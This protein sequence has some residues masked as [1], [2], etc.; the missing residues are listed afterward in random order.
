[1]QPASHR[2]NLFLSGRTDRAQQLAHVSLVDGVDNSLVGLN[3]GAKTSGRRNTFV[4]ANVATDASAASNNVAVGALAGETAADVHDNV[5]LGHAAGQRA[6]TATFNVVAGSMAGRD[7]RQA[8]FNVLLG[9]RAA[10]EMVSGARNVVLGAYA[11]YYAVNACDNVFAGHRAGMNNRL[12]NRNT[13][14]GA[15]TGRNNLRGNTNVFIGSDAGSNNTHGDDNVFLGARA[16]ENNT[17]G[18]NNVFVGVGSGANNLVGNNLVFFGAGAGANNTYGDNNV[19]IG[20]EAGA[21][22]DLGTDN[23]FIGRRAGYRNTI[24]NNNVFLSTSAGE[25]NVDGDNNVFIG[26]RAGLNNTLGSN[27]VFIATAAGANNAQGN[28]NVF[29]GTA[30]GLNSA[31]ASNLVFVGAGAGH[32]N[33]SGDDNVFVGPGVGGKNQSGAR[34]VFVGAM[35]GQNNRT[36]ANIVFIGAGAGQFCGSDDNTFVGAYA[37]WKNLLSYRNTYVG[38]LAGSQNRYGSDNVYL[39]ERA[40]LASN[41]GSNNVFIGANVAALN[42]AGNT[43]VFVGAEAGT[44]AT[45]SRNV[46]LG[47]AAGNAGSENVVAGHEAGRY[48]IGDANAVLGHG[49]ARQAVGHRNVAVGANVMAVASGNDNTI[50]GHGS[51]TRFDGSNNIVVGTK[52]LAPEKGTVNGSGFVLAD[53][54][55]LGG[56]DDYSNIQIG[57]TAFLTDRNIVIGNNV[58]NEID[59]VTLTNSVIIGHDVTLSKYDSNVLSLSTPAL[60]SVIRAE[61]NTVTFG[62]E[63]VVRSA[64]FNLKGPVTSALVLGQINEVAGAYTTLADDPLAGEQLYGAANGSPLTPPT[65]YS[66]FAPAE[67]WGS[68]WLGQDGVQ[69]P[70]PVRIQGVDYPYVLVN[71]TGG[72]LFANNSNSNPWLFPRDFATDTTEQNVSALIGP[73]LVFDWGSE[74]Y[75]GFDNAPLAN[76]GYSG[77]DYKDMYFHRIVLTDISAAQDDHFDTSVATPGYGSHKYLFRFERLRYSNVPA[78]A[79][80]MGVALEIT[81]IFSDDGTGDTIFRCCASPGWPQGAS[82]SKTLSLFGLD[83]AKLAETQV[84]APSQDSRLYFVPGPAPSDRYTT[85]S[86]TKLWRKRFGKWRT[87]SVVPPSLGSSPWYRYA[88][89]STPSYTSVQLNAP[90]SVLGTQYAYV[91]VGENGDV[92]FGL[93]DG[94]RDDRVQL[95]IGYRYLPI[96]SPTSTV[97]VYVLATQLQASTL[98]SSYFDTSVFSTGSATIIRVE[99]E[100]Q[101][102]DVPVPP[103]IKLVFAY[104]LEFGADCIKISYTDSVAL[105]K[106]QNTKGQFLLYTN[107]GI[108]T[109]LPKVLRQSYTVLLKPDPARFAYAGSN[110]Y[111]TQNGLTDLSG[112][113]GVGVGN[114]QVVQV[115]NNGLPTIEAVQ[116]TVSFH[117]NVAVGGLFLSSKPA[118]DTGFSGGPRVVQGGWDAPGA[119]HTLAWAALAGGGRDN[120]VGTLFVHASAR[121]AAIKR[122]G[123]ATLSIIKNPGDPPDLWPNHVHQGAGLTTFAF[124]VS[125]NDVVVTTDAECAVC[126]TFVAAY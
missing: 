17:L 84:Q 52:A 73:V 8:S 12:G 58:R 41:G 121:D 110:V 49:A 1:M 54:S 124:A 102:V 23:V 91:F 113:T 103:G 40:G 50:V 5:L 51:G 19:F 95:R 68:A 2:Q 115:F 56:D 99:Q 6:Q 120:V 80:S 78:N 111:I 44:R 65:A 53:G 29:I 60:G 67:Y 93:P 42:L 118:M 81:A 94:T 36:G 35:A 126:W 4:G 48:A 117:A 57:T 79:F 71:G 15:G 105:Y 63:S 39:G 90:I 62:T 104:E 43:N 27:N 112:R 21:A 16:G 107:N 30:A 38:T 31:N 11:A 34:N 22:N 46:F 123:T 89:S 14:L 88:F 75:S 92:M 87:P 125:G 70:R 28:D 109:R 25:N 85:W 47:F 97:S 10:G 72:I 9:H 66:E 74:S 82:F 32:D 55:G 33:V 116:G 64:T 83:G 108:E 61:G 76:L 37:G 122:N 86:V 101:F 20:G 114:A 96:L 18:S 98:P 3:A 100:C 13:F 26:P 59:A 24:G 77:A 106:D 119:T 45:G 7:M 69:L